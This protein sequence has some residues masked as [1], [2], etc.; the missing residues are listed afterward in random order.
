MT[1]DAWVR[2]GITGL[3]LAIGAIA[4]PAAAQTHVYAPLDRAD[5]VY[6]GMA[7]RSPQITARAWACYDGPNVGDAFWL[8][9]GTTAGLSGDHVVH[10][11]KS[12]GGAYNDQIIFVQY[13]GYEP[14]GDCESSGASEWSPL[15]YNGY[16][17]DGEGDGGNDQMVAGL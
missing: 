14:T 10:G 6:I 7:V 4:A 15:L 12:T 11:D 16:Y 8:T 17:A 9:L 1:R 13:A 3:L 5:N 2:T